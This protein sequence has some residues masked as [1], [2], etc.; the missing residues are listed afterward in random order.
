MYEQ[1]LKQ[2]NL[3][4]IQGAAI[5]EGRELRPKDIQNYWNGWYNSFYRKQD[6]FDI[7]LDKRTPESYQEFPSH[8]CLGKPEP[9][10]TW[11]PCNHENKPMIKWGKGCM[12]IHDAMCWPSC[13]YLAENMYMTKRIVIDIDGDHDEN[14]L[15]LDVIKFGS[16][17][18]DRTHC[19]AKAISV[20][21][22]NKEV[23]DMVGSL[24]V[25]YHLTFTVDK[26]IPTMHFPKSHLDIV[27]NARNSLRYYKNKQ[28]NG[29][30]PLPM[31]D[32]IWKELYQ[33]LEERK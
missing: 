33:F 17:W 32:E 11:V 22:V 5:A 14:N 26:L 24:P 19:I 13:M 3:A 12:S 7:S 25:S 18:I 27:G 30:A 16:Q 21:D 9:I 23:D 1:G 8:P 2:S 20:R 28:Y 6:L 10:R 31:T 15:D 4:L 29:L